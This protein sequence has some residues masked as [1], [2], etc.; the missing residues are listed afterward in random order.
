MGKLVLFLKD[1]TPFFSNLDPAL[2]Q[3]NPLFQ[4]LGAYPQNIT[5]AAGNFVNASL[6]QTETS[7]EQRKYI[8][9][10]QP[11][12]PQGLAA[13][14]SRVKNDRSNPYSFPRA[15]DGIANSS[16]PVWNTANCSSGIVAPLDPSAEA[17]IGRP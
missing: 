8:R 12:I 6:A 13:Y 14:P 4:F 2:A 11:F 9:T 10:M 17:A 15:L 3:L 16:I 5:S 1:A 7:G